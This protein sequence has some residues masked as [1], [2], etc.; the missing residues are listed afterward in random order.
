MTETVNHLSKWF[1]V[2][3]LLFLL[4]FHCSDMTPHW[5]PFCQCESGKYTWTAQ[6]L[7]SAV[8]PLISWRIRPVCNRLTMTTILQLKYSMYKCWRGWQCMGVRRYNLQRCL[9]KK[10]SLH[11]CERHWLV[12][13]NKMSS[14]P[15]QIQLQ[16]TLWHFTGRTLYSCSN[17]GSRG[18]SIKILQSNHK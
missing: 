17:R 7:L 13:I 9:E 8:S 6:F 12:S 4:F 2:C 14:C 10:V 11:S 1:L 15:C 16:E 5:L 18:F 3:F